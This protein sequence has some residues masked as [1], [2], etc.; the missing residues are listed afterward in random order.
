MRGLLLAGRRLLAVV[1]MGACGGVGDSG[2]P[3]FRE[4]SGERVVKM[5]SYDTLWA[6]GGSGDTL[7]SAPFRLTAAPSGGVY[8]LDIA[9]QQVHHLRD[10]AVQWS[11]GSIGEGPGEVRN[12]RGLAVDA[13]TGGPVVADGENQRIVWLS[14]EGN[15][16]RE[17]SIPGEGVGM[18]WN[19][20]ALSNGEFVLT[21]SNGNAPLLKVS[22]DGLQ[23]WPIPPPWQGFRSMHHIQW[24]GKAFAVDGG[25]WG[26]AFESGNGWF[27]FGADSVQAFPYVEH[28]DFPEVVVRNERLG[29]GR[30]LRGVGLL[31][32]PSYSGYHLDS[33]GDTLYVLP[34]GTSPVRRRVLDLYSIKSGEYLVS[35]PLP[36]Y[37]TRFALAGDTVFVIDRTGMFPHVLSLHSIPRR[38]HEDDRQ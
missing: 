27:V 15:W 5:V 23:G 35:R 26:F 31:S 7:L 6:Y 20:V 37:Y 18:V 2:E 9:T 10:G 16:I 13:E 21:T 11:W 14:A 4:G 3:L 34:G 33:R 36:G 29:F 38:E 1:G 22:R 30:T 19:M 12:I 25:R 28:V 17:V 32:E 24:I 8:V